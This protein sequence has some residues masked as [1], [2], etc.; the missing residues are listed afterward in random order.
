MTRSNYKPLMEAGVKIYEF[1]PGFI[2]S[3]Q[4]LVDE[5]IAIVGTINLDFR[6]LVHHFENGVLLYQNSCIKDIKADF[7]E[8]IRCSQLITNE[9]FKMSKISQVI[10][11]MLSLISTMM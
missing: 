11:A 1:T 8:T 10:N 2:H 5:E 9:N 4:I 7:E 6:S 3:K